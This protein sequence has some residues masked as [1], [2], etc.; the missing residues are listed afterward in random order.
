[1]QFDK[2]EFYL[3][4]AINY[5]SISVRISNVINVIMHS[6]KLLLFNSN[7]IWIKKGGDPYFDVAMGSYNGAEICELEHV[8]TLHVF[9]EK[10]GK[11]K[12]GLYCDDDL[13]FFRNINRS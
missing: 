5:A 6:R 7:N 1:M 8:H 10:Y 9:G 3:P 4:K 13:S 12:I 11:H 2:E